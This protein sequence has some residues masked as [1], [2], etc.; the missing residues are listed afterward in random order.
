MASTS[1][2]LDTKTLTLNDILGNGKIYF[3]PQYQRDYSW[4]QDNWEALWNDLLDAYRDDDAHY[5]GSIV[6]QIKG[7]ENDKQYW[8]IDGQ[9]RFATLSILILT[10]IDKIKNLAETGNDAENN[11]ERADLLMK[12]YIGQKDPSSLSYSSKLFLNENTDGFYQ[13]R[14]LHF[15]QPINYAKLNDAEKL[16]WDAFKYYREQMNALFPEGN[17][18]KIAAFLTKTVGESL[19]F[20]QITVTDELNAYTVFET[21]NSRGIELTATDLL[22]NFLLSLVSKSSSDLQMVKAQWKKIIDAVGLKKFPVFLRYYLNMQNTLVKQEQLFK[23][24]KKTVKTAQD[25]ID[26]LERLEKFA[27]IYNALYNPEDELWNGDKEIKEDISSLNLFRVTLC[28]PLLMIA[29]DKLDQPAFRKV[30]NAIVAISFR[31]NVIGKLQTNEMEK[32]YNN[33]AVKVYN[34]TLTSATQIIDDLKDLYL[35][36]ETFKRHFEL[37]SINTSNS[38]QKKIARYILYKIEGQLPDG[39]KTD[40]TTDDGT[41][42]HILPEN[43]SSHWSEIFNA[44]EHLR[45]VYMLGNLSLLENSKNSKE[46]AQKPFADK[47]KVYQTSRYALSKHI[48]GAEWNIKMI[49]HRQAGLAKT[50]CGIWKI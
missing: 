39:I 14:L 29:F 22:K 44:E 7:N 49:Q 8:I 50:A 32:A 11:R 30:L 10:A 38:Q 4:E 1:N 18:E 3:V 31:Y 6:L 25:V 36:D 26:L 34:A 46:A 16:L 15:K 23:S 5:M 28:Q 21:L 9:Q 35:D 20:I 48:T 41:I 40:Y 2:L 47:L 37:K 33:T 24:I 27:Y 45:N 43:M 17:G 42:E 13:Q 12:Q 19:K